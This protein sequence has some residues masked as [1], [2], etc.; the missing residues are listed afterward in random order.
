M[1]TF[2]EYCLLMWFGLMQMI[3]FTILMAIGRK[4]KAGFIITFIPFFIGV[5]MFLTF[6]TRALE[7]F[8]SI[9]EIKEFL[10]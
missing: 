2:N 3:P 10:K 1:M 4:N 7:T 8:P 6:G 5:I 9:A